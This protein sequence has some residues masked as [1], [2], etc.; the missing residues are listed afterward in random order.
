MCVSTVKLAQEVLDEK[1]FHKGFER[2]LGELRNLSG[3]GLITAHHGEP[4]WGI[5]RK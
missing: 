4:V 2:T 5:A 3:D 1:R